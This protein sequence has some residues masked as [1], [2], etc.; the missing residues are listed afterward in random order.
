M[1]QKKNIVMIIFKKIFRSITEYLKKILLEEM[2][3]INAFYRQ[4]QT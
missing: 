1:Q 4:Y 3:H 2:D